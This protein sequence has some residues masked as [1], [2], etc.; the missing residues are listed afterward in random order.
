LW[1]KKLKIRSDLDEKDVKNRIILCLQN[2]ELDSLG[3][4]RIDSRVLSK[5]EYIFSL[6]NKRRI[7][8]LLYGIREHP[9][10]FC[11]VDIFSN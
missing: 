10:R 4:I 8:L 5:R 6:Y 2:C 7:S 9:E 11:S 1:P 3:S